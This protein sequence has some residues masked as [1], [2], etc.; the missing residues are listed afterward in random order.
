VKD[1]QF[2]PGSGACDGATV[3]EVVKQAGVL[4]IGGV[5]LALRRKLA[6]HG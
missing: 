4:G 6:R 2:M 1:V 3:F 5:A